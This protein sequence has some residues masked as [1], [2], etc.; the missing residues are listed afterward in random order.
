[1]AQAP[2]HRRVVLAVLVGL[3][4][5]FGSLGWLVLTQSPPVPGVRSPPPGGGNVS[6][7]N[8]TCAGP[9]SPP[10]VTILASVCAG[11]G[12]RSV[13]PDQSSG[14]LY[15]TSEGSSNVSVLDASNGLQKIATVAPVLNAL[16][17]AID[18]NDQRA[19]VTNGLGDNV[20]VISTVSNTVVANFS[21]SGYYDL[22]AAQYD[23]FTKDVYFLSDTSADLLAVN[24]STYTIVQVIPITLSPG[25]T[26]F[27]IDPTTH[28]LYF[29]TGSPGVVE[30]INQTTGLTTGY[31]T[32]GV[33]FDPTTTFYD[34][35]NGLIYA[36]LGG[37]LSN[38]GNQVYAFDTHTGN[39][40]D[41]LSVGSR[42]AAYAYDP[43]RHFLYVSCPDSDS[44]SVINATSNQVVA[45]IDLGGR[46]LPGPVAVTPSNGNVLVG[47]DGTG[48]VIE[49]STA[50]TPPATAVCSPPAIPNGTAVIGLACVGSAPQSVVYDPAN[51]LVYVASEFSQNVSV[52]QSSD[53]SPVATIST[54]NFARG[55][56]LDSTN[57]LLYV[58]GDFGSTVAVVNTSTNV[59]VSSFDLTGYTNLV[60]A[61]YDPS[62]NQLFFLA[63]NNPDLVFVNPSTGSI[64]QVIPVAAN[65]GG[66]SGPIAAIDTTTHVIFFP[67]RGYYDVAL[68]GELNGTEFG[69]IPIT[70]SNGPTTTFYDAA[71]GLLYVMIGGLRDLGAGNQVFVFNATSMSLVSALT[72]G[73]FPYGY[74]YDSARGL[75]YVACAN[76]GSVYVI[77]TT[78]NQVA[79]SINLGAGSMP[80]NIAIDPITGDVFVAEDGTGLVLE[81]PP[82]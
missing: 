35:Q 65:P 64:S 60:G 13:A 40:V 22:V 18:P 79:T 46:S 67:D 59:V 70:G 15:V 57:G 32:M 76:S 45:S 41:R 63:N 25:P 75:L 81:L 38:P 10:S 53:L 16:G 78:T 80:G 56:A 2:D 82:A 31:V 77:N 12:I 47:E 66:G 61:Q 39:V 21:L 36:M 51:Q 30:A 42:P 44:I 50:S 62:V 33:P 6:A 68:I 11:Q 34:P 43:V 19:F 54:G 20:T 24:P 23:S 73:S 9:S 37:S 17:L 52:L 8:F 71:N 69:T 29:P 26:Q 14:D 74:A 72:V 28:T 48:L 4:V 3:V 1:M 58:S 27:A 55:L 5:V 49:F 7:T